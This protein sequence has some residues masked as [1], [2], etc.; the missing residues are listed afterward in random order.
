MK[1]EVKFSRPKLRRHAYAVMGLPPFLTKNQN[2][3]VPQYT[4]LYKLYFKQNSSQLN[5]LQRVPLNYKQP[6]QGSA[7]QKREFTYDQKYAGNDTFQLLS[8]VIKTKLSVV[9][10]SP[11][12]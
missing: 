6:R 1:F 11:M 10:F 4:I 12:R 7:E 2:Q 8:R 3:E 9:N 5:L